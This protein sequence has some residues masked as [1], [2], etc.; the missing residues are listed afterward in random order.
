M[1]L[2]TINYTDIQTRRSLGLC[3][4]CD[5]KYTPRHI[6]KNKMFN[7]MLIDEEEVMEQEGEG[8]W[9]IRH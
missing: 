7:F 4:R 1:K 5:E 8:K 2:K 3:F 6:Y 9:Y